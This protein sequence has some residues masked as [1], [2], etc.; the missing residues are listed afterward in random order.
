MSSWASFL[1]DSDDNHLFKLQ[2][3]RCNSLE[4]RSILLQSDAAA[5]GIFAAFLPGMIASLNPV[6]SSIMAGNAIA[7]AKK[8]EVC[9][10]AASHGIVLTH[11]SD[12][13]R[14]TPRS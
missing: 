11:N 3:F 13:P 10:K 8:G 12:E 1:L 6:R 2:R 5:T 9:K 4:P 7:A 14:S